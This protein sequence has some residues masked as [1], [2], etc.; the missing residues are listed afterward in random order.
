MMPV[1]SE[2]DSTPKGAPNAAKAET[3]FTGFDHRF[4]AA[5]ARLTGG[6]SPFALTEAYTDWAEHLLMSPD[7]QLELIHEASAGMARFLSYCW[8][9]GPG[10]EIP[11]CIEPLPQDT[12]FTGEEWRQWPFNVLSQA[13]LLTQDWWRK[14]ATGV[15]GVSKHHE[16]IVVFLVRQVLDTISPKN[17]PLTN[18]EV[19]TQT[20]KQGGINFVRGALNFWEDWQRLARGIKPVGTEAFEVGRD[21]AITPGK[22]VFRNRLIELIQY[23]PATPEVWAEPVLI[24]PAWIMKY[25]ILDLSPQNSLVRYLVAQGYTVFMISW[26]NPD[27]EDGDLGMEDYRE[28]GAMAAINAVSAIVPYSGIHAAGYC[29]GGT[30]LSVTAAAMARD[31]DTRLKSL[32]LFAAQTDFTEA[33]ELNMFI[34]E[35]Q[36]RFLEDMMTEKRYL[37]GKQM[38]GAFQLLRSNDLLWSAAVHEYLMGERP[39]MIDLMAWNADTTRL[40]YRMHSEYLRHFFL[41]NDLAEGRYEAGG[42]AVSLRDIH[43]PIFAVSTITDH[44]APWR[45]VYKIQMLTNADVTFVLSNGGHNAGIVSPPGHP[46]RHF[47]IATHKEEEIYVDPDS[48]QATADHVDGSWWPCWRDWLARHSSKKVPP[49]G[50]GAPEKGYPPLA[51][52]PG[53]YVLKP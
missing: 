35:A 33:G 18:P 2:E 24:I 30:L 4:H 46:H 25:Y 20:L 23:E 44:V 28:L 17:F 7:K 51:D 38:S 3:A 43:A 32:T 5:I 10:H 39:P 29:L 8:H 36:V 26:K 21:V 27:T 45:S 50:M 1:R 53:T 42:R 48:W 9:D 15:A 31:G 34:D 22:V 14:A 49:P 19:I 40:P 37:D 16:D 12:R 11:L 6:I 13:F 52:A 47:Q 41:R